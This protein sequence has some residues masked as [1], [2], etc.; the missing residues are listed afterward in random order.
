MKSPTRLRAEFLEI[1]R[2]IV[3]ADRA[4]RRAGRTQN[5]IGAIQRAMERA[6]VAGSTFT[7]QLDDE[8]V[9]WLTLAPKARAALDRIALSGFLTGESDPVVLT[10]VASPSGR[11]RWSLLGESN[12]QSST[13]ADGGVSSL[14]R[15]GALQELPDGRLEL[16]LLGREIYADYRRRRD[17]GEPMPLEGFR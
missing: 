17:A 1:A 2:T 15:A 9:N 4:A 13:L 14:L 12:D 3:S 11:L 10:P 7:P 6:F 5:T 16:S 8:A